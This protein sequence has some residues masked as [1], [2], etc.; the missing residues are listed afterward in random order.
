MSSK[1]KTQTTATFDP[2]GMSSYQSLQNPIQQGLLNNM[3][4]PWTAMAGNQQLA[5]S[6]LNIFNQE[7]T[8]NT[9]S[10]LSGRGIN[11]NSPLYQRAIQNAGLATK[12]QQNAGM[13]NL[14]LQ[15]GQL[16]QGSAIA[17]SQYQPLQTGQTSTNQ[18][19]GVGS[20]V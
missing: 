2:T 7:Q 17:A 16:S 8:S 3:S 18:T 20:Y 12:G 9:A 19:S 15:A 5:G 1:K 11:P 14:L 13:N 6:N 10:N 4:D